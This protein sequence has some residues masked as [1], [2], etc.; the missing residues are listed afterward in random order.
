[1]NKRTK[2][3]LKIYDQSGRLVKTLIND[4]VIDAG[5][6]AIEWDGCDAQGRELSSGIYFYR[7]ASEAV[8]QTRKLVLLK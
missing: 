3:N 8:T 5:Y 4:C 1:L 7:L 6:G 2:V